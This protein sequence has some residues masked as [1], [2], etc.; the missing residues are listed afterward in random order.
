MPSPHTDPH[1]DDDLRSA[2]SGATVM[3]TGGGGLVGSRIT[4]R[5]RSAGAR[6]IAVGRLDAY[7][8]RVYSE[9]FGVHAG[10][11]D[12]VVGDIADETLMNAMVRQ[13]DYVIHAAA[14]ADV[15]SCTRNPLA[16]L[17]TN[18]HGTQVLLGAVRAHNAKVRRFVFVSSAAVYGN[19]DP[20][21]QEVRSWHEEQPL[22]PL[23]VYANTKVWGEHQTALMTNAANVSHATVRYFSVYG[24]PQTVKEH[25]HSWVVAWLAMRAKLGLPLLLNGGGLQVRDFVHVDDVAEATIRA[26]LAPAAHQQVLN[27]GTGRA[28]SIREIA[29][30]VVQHYPDAPVE[31]RPLP[32][33]D[34]LG[35]Y[36]DTTRMSAALGW[37]PRI[38]VEQGV[39]RYVAWLD[40]TPG[41]LPDFLRE[42]AARYRAD[43]A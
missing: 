4:S 33:G 23:S 13:S 3:V 8:A 14:V 31:T 20:K 25:S 24:E 19:G 22:A 17:E 2:V 36:A 39:A 10:D 12:T 28:T 6:V 42:E 35:G 26:M 40:Q 1:T 37:E 27:V 21:R 43:I 41:A 18:V 32:E 38:S 11:R 15:A 7:P 29:D 16:A 5:L 34:P 9:L 30:M